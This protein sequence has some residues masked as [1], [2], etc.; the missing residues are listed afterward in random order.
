M[1]LRV[2]VSVIVTVLIR[3]RVSVSFI[4]KVSNVLGDQGK[5]RVRDSIIRLPVMIPSWL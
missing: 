4:V 1:D 2:G 3:I 5:V